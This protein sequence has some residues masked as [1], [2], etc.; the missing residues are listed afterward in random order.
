MAKEYSKKHPYPSRYSP[1][2]WVSAP[3]YI[4]ELICESNARNKKIELPLQ[5][6]QLEEWGK[7]YRWQIKLANELITEFGPEIIVKA[8]KDPQTK[9]ICSLK[10]PKLLKVIR[11][12]L[13]KVQRIEMPPPESQDIIGQEGSEPPVSRIEHTTKS[14]MGKL[15]G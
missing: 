12:L 7:Y 14:L 3:Q 2:G 1:G 8:L 11:D 9:F 5:F 4:T 10:S 13:S 15:N 6:W